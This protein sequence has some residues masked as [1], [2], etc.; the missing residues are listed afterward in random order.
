MTLSDASR[1]TLEMLKE[2]LQKLDRQWL[3]ASGLQQQNTEILQGMLVGVVTMDSQLR[4]H[5][6]NRAACQLLS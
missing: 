4:V 3:L 6:A 2:S 1:P 5:F